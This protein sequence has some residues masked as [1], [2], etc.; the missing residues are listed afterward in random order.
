MGI[1]EK[2]KET[3][4]IIGNILYIGVYIIRVILNP[5]ALRT[6]GLRSGLAA[7]DGVSGKGARTCGVHSPQTITGPVSGFLILLLCSLFLQVH[8]IEG[9]RALECLT[10]WV[11]IKVLGGWARGD[12]SEE[13]P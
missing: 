12:V 4:G 5:K 10:L 2:K 7:R 3:I 13:I 1:M 9:A 11:L 6:T 8:C